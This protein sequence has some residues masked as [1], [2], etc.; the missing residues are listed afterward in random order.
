[1]LPKE[2]R[3]QLFGT[4]RQ[5]VFELLAAVGLVVAVA[6]PFVY[7]SRLP[8]RIPVHFNLAGEPDAWGGRG[9][10]L[11]PP[12]VI[13]FFYPL[14][15]GASLLPVLFVNVPRGTP[16]QIALEMVQCVKMEITYLFA[17]LEWTSMQVALGTQKTTGLDLPVGLVIIFVTIAA[18]LVHMVRARRAA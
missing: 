11:V 16:S 4:G 9:M 14:L 3:A 18:Y 10:V 17:V 8:E 1:M 6:M 15:T 12:L 7:W 2:K 5:K 13:L